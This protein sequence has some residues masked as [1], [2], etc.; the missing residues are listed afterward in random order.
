MERERKLFF[1]TQ[2]HVPYPLG[3]LS[4]SQERQK[5]ECRMLLDRAGIDVSIEAAEASL[6]PQMKTFGG[7]SSC[8]VKWEI[9]FITRL[10]PEKT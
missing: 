6:T 10:K 8:K 9:L 4:I 7:L 2:L 3:K 1:L 5:K